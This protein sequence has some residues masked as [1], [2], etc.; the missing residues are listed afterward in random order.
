M[1]TH[2]Q[3]PPNQTHLLNYGCNCLHGDLHVQFNKETG[4]IETL[5]VRASEPGVTSY[6]DITDTLSQNQIAYLKDFVR[7][8][9]KNQYGHNPEE[10]KNQAA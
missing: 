7:R 10:Y 8:Q 9:Y 2:E 4:A 1:K 6:K 3:Q 5:E